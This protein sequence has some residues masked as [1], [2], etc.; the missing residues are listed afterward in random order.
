MYV[1]KANGCFS[2]KFGMNL[3]CVTLFQLAVVLSIA[4]DPWERKI[5]WSIVGFPPFL[6]LG[7]DLSV[8]HA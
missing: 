5:T 8:H 3:V 1:D 2:P 6:C 4:P 7:R